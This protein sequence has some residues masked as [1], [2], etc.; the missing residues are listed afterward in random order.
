MKKAIKIALLV[1][2][3]VTLIL[4]I[5]T[6]ITVSSVSGYSLLH[7]NSIWGSF[8]SATYQW[9]IIACLAFVVIWI[10]I[11][12]KCRKSIIFGI[13]SMA[14]KIKHTLSSGN[15]QPLTQNAPQTISQE[16]VIFCTKCGKQISS[17]D[18]FCNYCGNPVVK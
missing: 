1:F 4:I 16:T 15:N 17:A 9:L 12:I 13:N 14:V 3:A 6:V 8:C 7:A 18:K 2:A 11:A 5:F 10:I